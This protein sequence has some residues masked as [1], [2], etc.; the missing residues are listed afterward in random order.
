ML[1]CP[2]VL[3]W[4]VLLRVFCSVF[5]FLPKNKARNTRPNF[6]SLVSAFG[7]VREYI[8]MLRQLTSLGDFFSI[9][10]TVLYVCMLCLHV[11]LPTTHGPS[12]LG[13]PE[14]GVTDDT[15]KATAW[16]WV[17]CIHGGGWR[18]ER[19]EE[20]VWLPYY[21]KK[22]KKLLKKIV[23]KPPPL[24]GIVHSVFRECTYMPVVTFIAKQ[25][26]TCKWS[27]RSAKRWPPTPSRTSWSGK[28]FW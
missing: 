24:S 12:V 25:L 10:Q 22:Q 5:S 4:L 14:A 27:L 15:L 21:A 18:E 11:C 19:R 28:S 8:A 1:L 9:P 7:S 6:P 13:E 20:V 17:G 23:I 2:K 3:G 16:T 26:R